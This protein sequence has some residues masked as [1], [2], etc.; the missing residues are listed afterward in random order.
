MICTRIFD[1]W[2][3]LHWNQAHFLF[4]LANQVKG[5]KK[6]DAEENLIMVVYVI[7]TFDFDIWMAV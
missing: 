2:V 7:C 6:Y 3:R 1:Q 4:S 5:N